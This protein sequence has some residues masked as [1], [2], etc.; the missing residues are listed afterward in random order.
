M[1]L[2]NFSRPRSVLSQ[3]PKCEAPGAPIF[4]GCS[5]FP[6]HLGHPPTNF[7]VI[8]GAAKDLRLLFSKLPDRQ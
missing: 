6:R 1:K 2:L 4:I 7:A 5:H 8:L 3:V